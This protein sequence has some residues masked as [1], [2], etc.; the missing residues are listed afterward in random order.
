M[1][2]KTYFENLTQKCY[3]QQTGDALYSYLLKFE[4]VDINT[5]PHTKAR[6]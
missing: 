6:Q 5:I 3:T 2:N 1:Q 4:E